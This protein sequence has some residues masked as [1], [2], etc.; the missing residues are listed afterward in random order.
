MSDYLVNLA[1]RSAGITPVPRPRPV[2]WASLLSAA[3]APPTTPGPARAAVGPGSTPAGTEVLTEAN[4]SLP[5][6]VTRD[7]R[8]FQ[9]AIVSSGQD[10]GQ[11]SGDRDIPVAGAGDDGAEYSGDA[12]ERTG[13]VPA[14][15]LTAPLSPQTDVGAHLL[16][17]M[18]DL[19]LVPVTAPQQAAAAIPVSRA[20]LPPP[21]AADQPAATDVKAVPGPGLASGTEFPTGAGI[22][23][24]RVPGRSVAGHAAAE[25][26]P[27]GR[28]FHNDP[29]VA[30]K[31][32]VPLQ[33]Q[34]PESAAGPVAVV[35][36]ARSHTPVRPARAAKGAEAQRHVQVRIGTIEI[37]ADAPESAGIPPAAPEQAP[38][39]EPGGFE[40]FAMLRSYTP[41]ER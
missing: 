36:P 3:D 6:S 34:L 11:W 26:P 27:A 38:A 4:D 12:P 17:K 29:S 30:A 39:P 7:D 31:F 37:H 23:Q 41:W 28:S 32:H 22:D 1:R 10:R 16:P 21:S 33:P 15:G 13:A 40:S 24:R 9:V 35:P 19:P 18:P 5:A 2:P 20:A 14:A 8:T 25:L